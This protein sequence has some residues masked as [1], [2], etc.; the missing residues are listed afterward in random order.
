MAAL[1]RIANADVL[2]QETWASTYTADV[3]AT[4]FGW[5]TFTTGAALNTA[6]TTG[7]NT[8][9]ASFPRSGQ[10]NV[11]TPYPDVT[12]GM[13]T[14]TPDLNRGYMYVAQ[15]PTAPQ[16]QWT[17]EYLTFGNPAGIDPTAGQVSFGFSIANNSASRLARLA[18]EIGSN[19]YATDATYTSG[20]FAVATLGGATQPSVPSFSVNFAPTAS[21]WRDLAFDGSMTIDPNDGRA[22]PVAG[23][24]LSLATTPRTANLPAGNIDAWGIYW[25]PFA[26]DAGGNR[27]VDSFSVSQL[28]APPLGFN[29][30]WKNTPGGGDGT[31][32]DVQTSQNW[33]SSNTSDPNRYRDN[34]LVTFS[35][36]NNGHYTVN[37]PGA[38]MPGSVTVNSTGNYTF[39]GAGT[40][41]GNGGL[42]VTG[43]GTLNL[44]TNNT[45]A[46]PT[47]I[48]SGC[49]VKVGNGGTV[50][51]FGTGTVT[52]N[53]TIAFNRSDAASSLNQMD[54]AG[55]VRQD[56]TG[57]LTLAGASSFT[58]GLTIN[59]GAVRVGSTGA[60]TGTITVAPNTTLVA[61]GSLP[62]A[63]IMNG[64]VL[65]SAGL[66]TANGTNLTTGDVTVNA[67]ITVKTGD[68]QVN[69]GAVGSEVEFS[70]VLH[71]KGN[72]LAT[73]DQVSPDGGAG[74][75]L[76]GTGASDYS[77]TLT[78]GNGVKFE[79]QTAQAG[80]FSPLG[81]GKV[82]MVAGS[83]DT[84]TN[85]T[86]SEFQV[87][88]TIS[89]GGP[90]TVPTNIEITGSGLADL[91]FPATVT[92][93][94][95]TLGNLKIG[96]QTLGVN[97]NNGT[98]VFPAVTLTGTPTFA[99]N[100]PGFGASGAAS[101]SLGPISQ[102]SPG[103]G[104]TVNGALTATVTLT[105]SNTYTGPTTVTSGSL[106]L[107]A[108]NL[109]HDSSNLVLNGGTF[110]SGGFSEKMNQ[111]SVSSPNSHIDLGPSFTNALNFSPSGNVLW[112]AAQLTIDNWI[113]G[114]NHIFVGTTP[115][116]AN[117]LTMGLS[118][119]QLMN[120]TFT[121]HTPGAT[122]IAGGEL[123]PQDVGGAITTTF[124]K[125][126]MNRDG[127]V[128]AADV[129]SMLSALTDINK[130]ATTNNRFAS[131]VA[132]VGDLDS[133]GA[134]TNLDLQ[135]LLG[136]LAGGGGSSVAP[137]P[138]P[139]AI[140]LFAVG[141]VMV[142]WRRR[143]QDRR[144]C[145]Q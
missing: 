115:Y 144:W 123:V 12:V 79:L 139:S 107:G 89:G 128:N 30:L 126:D 3:S 46:G 7:I 29:V 142:A 73:A 77:G 136:L 100:T 91:N 72:I 24:T 92:N 110:N 75:R 2:Y 47:T 39:Q 137:V 95:I 43:G 71:G 21:L 55:S 122:L 61:T 42:K 129:T 132:F 32:W 74:F 27:R 17:N 131:D 104:I 114:A 94:V 96:G 41:A 13:T 101:L 135:S 60:G 40:I 141:G 127:H 22:T 118:A 53:G 66:G 145:L 82:V 124:V 68:P 1:S 76:H 62:N 25:E 15:Q 38:V 19:W 54:G 120:I 57:T 78:V 67:N 31:T 133:D 86:Y 20:A 99:P 44:L 112:N 113:S 16:L 93:N 87:R 37:I 10:M 18:I 33:N 103:L 69:G 6:N 52:N 83:Y 84:T 4:N 140:V 58:G 102:S 23:T 9:N 64:G 130:F 143:G 116:S 88:N 90:T 51:S 56:G 85:G 98:Y 111:L 70:G 36:N 48:D 97:K 14:T 49:T 50:G 28:T 138:E 121:G 81:T 119:S 45:Y 105:G 11:A 109:I 106:V 59:N 5:G 35:D 108:D 125:G 65:G 63:I 34:D 134:F 26:G 117:S 8:A 80:P